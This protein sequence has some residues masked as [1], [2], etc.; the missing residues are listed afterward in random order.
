MIK[1]GVL[2]ALNAGDNVL[3]TENLDG[4][5]ADTIVQYACFGELVYG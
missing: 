4:P 5:M 3:D 2:V 1:Q